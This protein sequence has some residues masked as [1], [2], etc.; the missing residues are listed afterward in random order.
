MVKAYVTQFG[1]ERCNLDKHVHLIVHAYK[2]L[3][4]V[5]R[6]RQGD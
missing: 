1:V 4:I 5:Q 2:H 6:T 3:R